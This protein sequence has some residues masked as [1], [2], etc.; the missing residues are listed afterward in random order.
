MAAGHVLICVSHCGLHFPSIFFLFSPFPFVRLVL[1]LSIWPTIDKT[2]SLTMLGTRRRIGGSG[3]HAL[4][5]AC[6]CSGFRK[7]MGCVSRH[8][9]STF[10]LPD[11]TQQKECGSWHT[12]SFHASLVLVARFRPP[13]LPWLTLLFWSWFQVQN[14]QREAMGGG[15]Q[16]DRKA[17][18]NL[19]GSHRK[20]GGS[21]STC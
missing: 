15:G 7:E 18:R 9:L 16:R 20:S 2:Q 8:C 21:L 10:P 5:R 12:P 3:A 17:D 14:T 1:L 19:R 4:W 6:V 11:G 13:S